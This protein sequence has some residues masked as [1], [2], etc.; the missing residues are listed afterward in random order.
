[1][2][3]F[4]LLAQ[5]LAIW[6]LP[7]LLALVGRELARALMA[8]L[9]GHRVSLNPLRWIDPVGGLLVPGALLALG[10]LP[11]GWGRPMNLD[12]R[13]LHARPWHTLLVAGA[14][15]GA[16]LCLIAVA[17]ALLHQVQYDYGGFAAWPLLRDLGV[18]L[19]TINIVLLLT[20]AIPLPPLDGGRVAA[21]LLKPAGAE[22]LFRY[23]RWVQP[24][25]ALLM[26]S[27]VLYWLLL[28]PAFILE[29][30]ILLGLGLDPG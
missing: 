9:L 7:V 13:A 8:R 6:A 20:N 1:M 2:T 28:W 25:L 3:E 5:Q 24:A 19:L 11:F 29:I 23:A 18:A 22:R 14:G 10:V 21:L 26:A 17:A 16:S 30:K 15:F 27:G 4:P 12:P